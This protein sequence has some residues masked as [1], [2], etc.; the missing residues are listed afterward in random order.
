[1]TART[2]SPRP[3]HTSSV[4]QRQVRPALAGATFTVFTLMILMAFLSPFGYMSVTALKDRQM[5]T[6]PGSPILPSRPAT[7]TYEGNEYPVLRV[8]DEDGHLHEWA[9]IKKGREESTFID[10]HHPEAGLIQWTG[11]WRTLEPA[12]ELSPMWE[13]F[14]YAWTQ[15]NMPRLLRNT[16]LIAI[17]GLIG[18]VFSCTVVAYGFT[19]F[20]I[21]GKNIL[22]LLLVSTMILPAFV[23]IVPTYI[24]FERIGWMGTMLPLMVPHFFANAYNVFLLR[25]YFLTIPREMDEA[26]M[27]DGAGPIRTLVS[28]ILPQSIP[29]L[30]AVGIFHF[31]WAWNDFFG[32]LLYLSTAIR[33][34]PIA[35][36]IQRFNAQFSARP[37]MVQSS[38]LL[39]LLLPVILF[40]LAQR[41]FM[42]GIVFTGVEK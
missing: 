34:Q 40:F 41:V 4:L 20:R 38:A 26:A 12:W 23:T 24:L 27:I 30:V 17:V 33:L 15:L 11:R 14:S 1:M 32:P 36:G 3:V 19:R 10:P 28:V 31:M 13:N 18:T 2:Q 22:F 42:R 35:I 39:G 5:I 29:V 16:L 25:Q 21:P 37:H 7:F 8:P 6:E 9:I